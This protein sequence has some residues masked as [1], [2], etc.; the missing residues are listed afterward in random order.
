MLIY[1]KC[2]NCSNAITKFYR[3][4]KDVAS[5]FDCGHCSIGKLERQMEAPTSKTTQV[6][7]NGGLTKDIELL[8]AVVE[9]EREKMEA[10]MVREDDEDVEAE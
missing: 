10:E 9:K 7:D 2:N 3:S 5:F 6:V 1:Y 4:H 8:D